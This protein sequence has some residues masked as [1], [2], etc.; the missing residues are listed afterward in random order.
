M[1]AYE[2]DYPHRYLFLLRN[3]EP[4]EDTQWAEQIDEVGREIQAQLIGILTHGIK[5]GELRSDL[6]VDLIANAI[7]GML[8]WTDRW[9]TPGRGH[10]ANQV[11]DC[12]T[13]LLLDG[14][15]VQHRLVRP[16]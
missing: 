15:A 4:R 7:F 5:S 8:N 3:D 9:F 6:P 16:S 12:F 11:G 2:A 10:P 1:A 14:P 13:E